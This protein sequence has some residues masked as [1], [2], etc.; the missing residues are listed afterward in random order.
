MAPSLVFK[1][2]QN[3]VRKRQDL[4]IQTD[5]WFDVAAIEGLC[6]CVKFYLVDV[7]LP[8]HHRNYMLDTMH[9]WMQ[10]HYFYYCIPSSPIITA[11]AYAGPLVSFRSFGYMGIIYYLT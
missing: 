3:D 11:S 1:A 8:S 2:D 7:G 4:R 9:K 10:C 6:T 5:H